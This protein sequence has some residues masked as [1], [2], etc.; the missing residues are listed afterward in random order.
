[1]MVAMVRNRLVYASKI[2]EVA[3]NSNAGVSICKVI[4]F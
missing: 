4:L 2:K 3:E 1:M